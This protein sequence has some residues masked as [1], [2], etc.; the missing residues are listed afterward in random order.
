MKRRH[1]Q[2]LP[3]VLI[4]ALVTLLAVSGYSQTQTGN[5]YGKV[6]SKDGS[7]LPGVTVVLT[8]VG[9]PQTFITDTNGAFRFLNLSPGGYNMRAELSGFG[10]AAREGVRVS[11]GANA[12]VTMT[13]NPSITESITVTAQAPLLDV[14]RTGT[15][16]TMTQVELEKIPSARDPWV[17]LQQTPGVLVDR[18]NVGGNESGQQSNYV[19]KGAV[20]SQSTWNVDGVNIT[21][22][23]ALGSS[24]TYYDFDSFEEMQITTG[25]ADPRIQTPGVQLNMVT[26]RG[27]NDF[28]GSGRY[29]KTT[30]S[31][32][33]DPTIP[34][35]AAKYLLRVNEIENITDGGVEVGGPVLTDKL[36]FW[37]AYSNQNINLLTATILA[38]SRFI[39]QTDLRAKNAK[40]N[41]QITSSNSL[42][43][44]A[45]K[46]DKI[47]LGRNVGPS[48]LPVTSWNQK[49][50]YPGPTT[51]KIEDTQIFS[52][53]FYLTGLYSK[54]EGG[55]Q[56]IADNGKRCQDFG[57]GL[58]SAPAYLDL[59]ET[60]AWNRSYVSYVTGR[61]S[62]Q[63]RA[64]SAAFL[65]TGSINHELKFGFGYRDADVTSQSAWPQDQYL[66]LS[67]GTPGT[68]GASG[69]VS[70]QR[71]SNFTYN[72]QSTDLY[73]GDTMMF[74]NFAVQAGLRYDL[75]EG[76]V[77]AGS[78]TA[79]AAVPDLLPGIKWNEISGLE[80][81]SIS[82]RV[83]LTYTVG[84][85]RKT[86]LRAG[87]NRYVDQLGGST[88]YNPSP[89][90]YQY[91]YY[92]FTDLNG[93]LRASRRTIRRAPARCSW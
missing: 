18:V 28:K 39:D 73:V 13:L 64:D 85:D 10:A 56:L 48:R 49:S 51:W 11:V 74:G 71:P 23:G 61:P 29:Y 34:T 35:E 80:W 36:W 4:A 57:C 40:F 9:A 93:D 46:G 12:D 59:V 8:G 89:G 7:I 67:S 88:V 84:A 53:N 3:A 65:S 22:V 72:V 47:K 75:Q 44:S 27:S 37:G 60:G 78:T 30:N 87:Y 68:P 55:F 6:V 17:M 91:L 82:P 20:G 5:I 54:V 77:S 52:P 2:R 42:N 62:T 79:N 83:G 19:G 25:G 26:K 16:A 81:K 66:V 58:D 41:A 86:L 15:G 38:G 63:Y 45:M 70:F 90:G 21:D 50:S 69:G 31:W 14:R 1:P 33:A 92:Y 32:Q 24:P 76:A 43:I